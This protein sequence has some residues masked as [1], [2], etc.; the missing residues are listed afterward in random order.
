MFRLNHRAFDILQAE[1][2]RCSGND[3][4]GQ[5]QREILLKRLEKLRSQPGSLLSLAELR[6]TVID[7]FPNFSESV[8]KQAARANRPAGPWSKLTAAAL[9]VAGTTGGIYILNLPYPMIRW[10]VARTMPIVLLPSFISM[11]HH[12]RQATSLVEQSDQLVN[13]AT[14]SADINL[15]EEKIKAAQKHLDAL[16]VWFLGY[17]PQRYCS[18]F[19]CGWQFT[20][21]EFETARKQIGRMEAKVF[22]EKNAQT[23]LNQGK[24]ALSTA[25]QQ[26]QQAKT[27]AARSAAIANWQ[28]A[29]DTLHQIPPQT[30]AGRMAQTHLVA[31]E[32]DFQQVAG[33]A[34]GNVRTG[35]LIEAARQFATVAAQ[36]GQNPPHTA[37]EWTEV[38]NLWKKAIDHLEKV[39]L[40]DSGY[41]DAQRF[42]ATYQRNLGIVRTRLQAEEESRRSLELAQSLTN[43]ILSSTPI[44]AA[45]TN[46]GY[47]VSQ[48]QGVVNQTKKV[49]AG[50]TAYPEAQDLLRSAQ[51][52]LRQLQPK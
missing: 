6:E 2:L 39:P 31:Y 40:E 46:R 16:P 43:N 29:I 47:L 3:L 4:A 34:A 7:L 19:Q 48:L 5:V 15:G 10:P 37:T 52:K 38:A 45:S 50:T 22:Q 51:T 12:Y 33:F 20:L 36:A 13:Q 9:V 49:Q 35:T 42:L 18:L 25:K 30:L 1:V 26:F 27:E 8:L 11:D 17:F 14:A 24:T 44:D 32:R 23:Q 21:D 28:E 41:L